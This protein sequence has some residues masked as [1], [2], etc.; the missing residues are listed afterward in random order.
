M[1]MINKNTKFCALL[2]LGILLLINPAYAAINTIGPGQTVFIGEQGLDISGAIGASPAIGWWAS[3]ASIAGSAPDYSINVANPASFYVSPNEF[4]TRTGSWYALPAK[5][6]AFNVADP[7]LDIIVEDTTVNVDVTDRWVPTGDELR[8]RIDTNLYPIGGRAG[9]S[10]TPVT[11]K[12]KSPDGAIFSSLISNS[13]V[14]TSIVDYHVTSA[15]QYTDSIWGTNNRDSYP[16]GTYS[17]WA[18]CNVNGMK[19]KY[20]VTGKTIS[21]TVSLLNQDQN[22]LIGGNVPTMNPTQ[23][24]VPTSQ[25]T[26]TPT[27]KVTT[28]STP[29]PT[30]SQNT[31]L[32]T[33]TAPPVITSPIPEIAATQQLPIPTKTKSPGFESIL[34]GFALLVALVIC[35][36]NE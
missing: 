14:S 23:T 7:Q 12:V 25:P 28:I 27:K 3:G 8:F 17:I 29:M 33:L 15:P 24:I 31:P 20:G 11:I 18:E 6:L 2:I 21:R 32:P 4:S 34:A 26:N 9:Q 35:T 13:G 1:N 22:P 36:K 19:D 10:W 5:T 30:T 16:P